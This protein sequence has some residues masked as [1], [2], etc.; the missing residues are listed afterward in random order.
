[1][2]AGNEAG[3]GATLF[4][5]LAG[6]RRVGVV[7]GLDAGTLRRLIAVLGQALCDALSGRGYAHLCRNWRYRDAPRCV[8]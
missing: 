4:V 8:T 5:E 6:G 7:S 1:V 3:S 2:I